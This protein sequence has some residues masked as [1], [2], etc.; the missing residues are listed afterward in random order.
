MINDL[1]Y[2]NIQLLYMY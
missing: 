1:F 2:N